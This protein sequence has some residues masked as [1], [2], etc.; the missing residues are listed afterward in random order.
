MDRSLIIGLVAVAG[1]LAVAGPAPAAT[2]APAETNARGVAVTA[3]PGSSG[4]GVVVWTSGR[5]GALSVQTAALTA[6]DSFG[7]IQTVLTAPVLDAGPAVALHGGGS[8]VILGTRGTDKAPTELVAMRR[9]P[10]A[11]GYGAPAVLAT[12]DFV[13]LL[14]VR[15]NTRGDIAAIYSTGSRH[16]ELITAPAG[17]A[18]GTPQELAAGGGLAVQ[19]ALA[20]GPQGQLVVAYY[21]AVSRIQARTGDL[22]DRLGAPKS[23]VQTRN[24]SDISAAVDD[25]GNATIAFSRSLPD[26]RIG[27]SYVRAH[28]GGAFSAPKTLSSGPNAQR[29]QLVAAGTTTAIA[30]DDLTVAN[31][32]RVAIAHGASSF[33]KSQSPVTPPVLL[34]GEAGRFP[35]YSGEPQLAVDAK[36]DVLAAYT[37]GPYQAALHATLLRAGDA[38]FGKPRLVSSLGHGGF[39]A[40]ALLGNRRPLIAYSDGNAVFA[41]TELPDRHPNLT[42]PKVTMTPLS[43]HELRTAG[44]V[45]TTVRCSEACFVGAIGRLTTGRFHQGHG[46]VISRPGANP[47][48]LAAGKSLTLHFNLTPAGKAALAA[49][50]NGHAK[51]IVTATN[52]SGTARSVRSMIDFG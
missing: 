5:A 35:S 26:N 52:A 29:P 43:A 7:P 22:A 37:Y 39:P 10:G 2:I 32:Q 46:Q 18:F 45:S 12:G 27:V 49:S 36:G 19:P 42:A 1:A 34:H 15:S 21:D 4:D 6:P 9:A 44:R 40:V 50:G 17:G 23:L 14:A 3:A 38:H 47:V 16:A 33:G 25:A 30:W 8:S 24:Y 41:V 28:A 51:L 13:S 11:T 48:A 20:L 31:S